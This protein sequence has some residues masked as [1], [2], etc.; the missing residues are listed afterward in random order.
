MKEFDFYTHE[1]VRDDFYIVTESYG[2]NSCFRIYVLIGEDKIAVIDTGAGAQSGLRR[3]IETFIT[4]KTP[5]PMIALLTHTHPDHV[6]GAPLF[7][8]VYVNSGEL[9]DL[10]WNRNHYRR[11]GDLEWFCSRDRWV[12]DVDHD[13]MNFCYS[14]F[15]HELL[16][17]EDCK[18]AEDGM[19]IDIGGLK[20]ECIICPTHSNGSVC[21][22]DRKNNVC[23]VG[24][25]I[26]CSNSFK[27]HQQGVK[28]LEYIDRFISL[29]PEDVTLYNG[30]DTEK[31][32]LDFVR[33][34][35]QCTEDLTEKKN[36]EN[37]GPQGYRNHFHVKMPGTAAS[38]AERKMMD[39][40][41]GKARLS[42]N[43]NDF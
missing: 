4:G 33:D 23:Y 34:V 24:D 19:V 43:Q 17:E 28:N 38:A 36:L 32:G 11:F 1:K 7:D 22:Y 37:D 6:G 35:R 25:A 15:V 9:P 5:K 27:N 8:E 26:Q 20:L 16:Q 3:Y 18:L 29:M 30:H 2:V 31:F 10:A 14:N 21:Y 39:H 12:E 13:I 40:Y 41:V 42:Y